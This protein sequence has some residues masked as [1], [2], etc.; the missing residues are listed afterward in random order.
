MGTQ[1]VVLA[2]LVAVVGMP[3]GGLDHR[4]G[5]AVLRS[6]AGHRW[7]I[8][9]SAGYLTVMAAVLAGWVWLPLFTLAGFVLL[10]AAHFGTADKR[11]GT[12]G[13]LALTVLQGGMVVW[14]PVLFQPAEFTR[15]LTWV[16]P[17]N[18][19]PEDILFDASLRA[20]LWFALGVVI[21]RAVVSRPATAVRV[22]AFVVLFAVA[23]PLLGFA[24]YF[25]GWHS[26]VELVGLARQANPNHPVAGL[27]RVLVAAAPLSAAAVLLA[28]IG[29]GVASAGGPL[30]PGIVQAVFVGL[31][32]VAVPHMLL[33]MIAARRNVNPFAAEGPL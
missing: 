32:V 19:W 1:A 5:R 15:L 13:G 18:R 25:C 3:H 11:P 26:V 10:S 31:S 17:R 12:T 16:V 6:V 30:T 33:H 7:V 20:G 4:V 23:P 2:A 29:W 8:P 21:T 14:V 24:V 28:V 9:F 22:V 27:G